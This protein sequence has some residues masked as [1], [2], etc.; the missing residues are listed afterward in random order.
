MT[1]RNVRKT[2]IAALA[3]LIVLATIGLVPVLAPATAQEEQSACARISGDDRYATAAEIA[4]A[5]FPGGA[6]YVL[7][8]R[9]D[10]TPANPANVP[11]DALAGSYGAGHFSAP[12]LL[13]PGNGPLP[14]ET[15][16]A[17]EALGATTGTILGL[18]AA[19]SQDVEDEL[20]DHLDSVDRVGGSDR[21]AT[22]AMIAAT[23]GEMFVNSDGELS[24]FLA[25]GDD[26]R[27][28]A[29]AL[30]AGGPAYT[31]HLPILLTPSDRLS[32]AAAEFIEDTDVE[33][34]YILGG[35]VAVSTATE[36]QVKALNNAGTEVTRLAGSDRAGTAIDVAVDFLIAELGWTTEHFNLA[37]GLPRNL[38]D[39]VSGGP[40]AGEEQSMTLL[41][42]SASTLGAQTED[43]LEQLAAGELDSGETVEPPVSAHVLGGPAAISD[44]TMASACDLAGIDGEPA[45]PTA[46]TLV[47]TPDSEINASGTNH[48]VT[49]SVTDENGDPV[50][51]T[52]VKFEL[53][54]DSD[55]DG[56]FAQVDAAAAESSGSNK[57]ATA[58]PATFDYDT[59]TG[60]TTDTDTVASDPG[61]ATY[62]FT[63][64]HGTG[65]YLVAACVDADADAACAST[66]QA[67]QVVLDAGDVAAD[68]ARKRF[69]ASQNATAGSYSGEVVRDC[70]G[71]S[72]LPTGGDVGIF[73]ADKRFL[74]LEYGADLPGDTYKV[75]GDTVMEGA[76][77][78][79]CSVGDTLE[80]SYA[81]S[82]GS[83]SAFNL[84]ED[85]STG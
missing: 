35:T 70:S 63:D 47:L 85:T 45:E 29:D 49:A 10:G 57:Q 21:Y 54:R 59:F 2:G 55:S 20:E 65:D 56:T 79:A 68:T 58:P 30:S 43:F 66:N 69:V 64:E 22:A 62:T 1:R 25:S 42:E 15:I 81:P 67:G 18:E 39:A 31:E 60:G 5:T 75:N 40:H 28:G 50:E 17:I 83:A 61:E 46:T 9:G 7:I 23:P 13:T 8:A 41:A 71:D 52:V 36:T 3:A 14:D 73:T 12:I 32:P 6:D 33:R 26:Q 80:S 38:V 37:S 27:G 78:T 19:V 24:T 16:D 51:E 74:I 76:F 53:F 72:S 48:T 84:T 44:K 4:L 77:E 82:Q 34:V 11:F